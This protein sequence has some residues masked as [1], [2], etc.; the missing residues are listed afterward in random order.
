[1]VSDDDEDEADL[2]LT[3]P[4]AFKLDY[5]SYPNDRA[6]V[7]DFIAE[8][9]KLFRTDCENEQRRMGSLGKNFRTEN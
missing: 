7:K 5:D 6:Y 4:P 3:E 2:P 1:M 8:T 9:R